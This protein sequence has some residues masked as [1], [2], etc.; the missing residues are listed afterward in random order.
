MSMYQSVLVTIVALVVLGI[1]G[2]YILLNPNSDTAKQIVIALLPVLGGIG[3]FFFHSAQT[4]FLGQQL[5]AQRMVTV[6]AIRAAT[7]SGGAAT[8]T[9]KSPG[10]PTTPSGNF[11]SA[12]TE[13]G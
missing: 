11:G 8:M 4:A 2:A 10:S 13:N 1:V 5:S 3:Y 7:V 9:P 12:T 6:E